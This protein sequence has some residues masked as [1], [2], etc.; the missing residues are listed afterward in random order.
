MTRT[1]EAVI[2][3]QWSTFFW[4]AVG[5]PADAHARLPQARPGVPGDPADAALGGLVL[6]LMGWL[7]IKLDM[8][9][10]LV[11]SVALGLSVDDTFHCLIQF[12]RERQT[13]GVPREPVRQLRGHR[14]RRPAL[15]PGR[16]RRL[17]RAAAQRV[18]AVR[19]LRHDG[20]H[21]HRGQHA[22]QPRAPARLPDAGASLARG[23]GG[24][25][26]SRSG[27]PGLKAGRPWQSCFRRRWVVRGCIRAV[28]WIRSDRG[29]GSAGTVPNC[30]DR[31]RPNGIRLDPLANEQR[32]CP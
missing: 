29:L 25:G 19:Q 20:R 14:P 16:R 31:T 28:K 18:R 8:A 24:P 30:T 3:T 15:E 1:T 27:D 13:R 4:S 6:G 12:H 10:A 9:T 32:N 2:A 26:R 11:A 21:R 5:H 17:R 7:G 22:R 23:Q